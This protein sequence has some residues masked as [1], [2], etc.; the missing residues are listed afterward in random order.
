[1]KKKKEHMISQIMPGSIAEELELE[2]GDKE[3]QYVINKTCLNMD[4]I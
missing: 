2:T 1:M 3:T 4:N